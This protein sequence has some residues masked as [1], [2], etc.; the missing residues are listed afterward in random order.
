MPGEGPMKFPAIPWTVPHERVTKNCGNSSD[1][2]P[3]FSVHG[4]CD[5]KELQS[6]IITVAGT[7]L[8]TLDHNCLHYL[9]YVRMCLCA[10]EHVEHK[11]GA[12]GTTSRVFFSLSAKGSWD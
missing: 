11:R 2:K 7:C 12:Q 5:Y 4:L 9:V 8:R 3:A 6:K 1:T 10:F